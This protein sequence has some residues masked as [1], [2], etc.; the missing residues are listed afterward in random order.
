[1]KTLLIMAT[2]LSLAGCAG[3]VAAPPVAQP[4]PAVVVP[5]GVVAQADQVILSGERA[6]AAAE[7]A[8]ITAADG[9]GRLAELGV[10]RGAAATRVRGLNAQAR[11]LLVRGKAIADGAEKAR[12]AAQLFGIADVL[13]SIRSR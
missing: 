7:L 12:I 3:T 10:I 13:K 9:V 5:V 11:T 1:M 4:A 6:F 2:A 8:Y